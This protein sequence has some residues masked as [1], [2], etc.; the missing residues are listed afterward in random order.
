MGGTNIDAAETKNAEKPATTET[1]DRG[2]LEDHTCRKNGSG[3]KAHNPRRGKGLSGGNGSTC[4]EEM[5]SVQNGPGGRAS[6]KDKERKG[7]DEL[8]GHKKNNPTR[9]VLDNSKK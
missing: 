6:A 5:G 1:S 7:G 4:D 2:G 9:T 8:C 3:D